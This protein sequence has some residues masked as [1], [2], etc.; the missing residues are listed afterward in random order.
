MDAKKDKYLV[1]PVEEREMENRTSD[2]EST[3]RD[4]EI[5]MKFDK[6]FWLKVQDRV[7]SKKLSW[8]R[9][10]DEVHAVCL[11]EKYGKNVLPVIIHKWP[12]RRKY[13][14]KPEVLPSLEYLISRLTEIILERDTKE[15]YKYFRVALKDDPTRPTLL[16]LAAEQNFLHVSKALVEHYP[17]LMYMYS[18]KQKEKPSYL[19]V[20][21]ALKE[22][23]DDT[24]AYLISQMRHDRV[25]KLFLC[26]ENEAQTPM[27]FY[28][29]DY[30]SCQDAKTKEPL[31][32]KTVLA[33]LDKHINPRWPYLP[34]MKEDE[35]NDSELERAF[36]SV[37]DDP[38]NYDFFFHILE[39]D[40]KGRQP[41]I[42]VATEVDEHGASLNTGM[43]ANPKF[44]AKSLS[45]LRRIA[46]S[47][48]KEAIQHPVV[49]ML[50][51][52]KWNE[53]AHDWFCVQA[54]LYVLFLTVLSFA[55]IH[56]STQDDPTQYSGK[57]NK[58]RVICE[59]LSIIFLMFYFFEEVNQAGRE[60][61]TYFK[62]PYNYF[63]WLGLILTFLV[64]PL[65][66][67]GVDS[68]WSVAALGYLFNFLRLFKFSCVTRTT[69]LY[70]KTLAKIVYRDIS[71][72]CVVFVVIF[73]GFCGSMY[74]ALKATASQKHFSNFSW[75]MLAAV[76]ALFEQQPVEE[77]Y[78][79]FRWLA[80][81]ILLSYMAM[82]IVIM[83]NILIA[84]MSYTYSEA[85]RTAK[86]QFAVDTML[87][88]ARLE[89]SRFA[90]WNLR[91]K[92]YIKGVWISE[93][94]LA[95]EMLEY[96]EDSHPWETME[97]KLTN[98][99]RLMRK[100]VR[101]VKN[102]DPLE[103]IDDKLNNL[104]K[105]VEKIPVP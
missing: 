101:R 12:Q 38:M 55:L 54:A 44:N 40:D 61:Q 96:S 93:K 92:N 59:V 26:Q 84:Q 49:R 3:D 21:L 11:M 99:R 53:F 100:V 79:K 46:E 29:G 77:D 43:I 70:T 15:D 75:L 62:D 74:M 68:Q 10:M 24:A 6:D 5:E 1:I 8:S 97:E 58:L 86:L 104:T 85:K 4:D 69:G 45:C 91:V 13:A 14:K 16:H 19:P 30:I 31:M 63:D 57:A 25:Q 39:A 32:K 42:E 102:T 72:F 48:H 41:K 94:D 36:S 28:F 2:S 80:I 76:R 35:E 83:L 64:I 81:L 67:V 71:R 73:L 89:Y 60:W 87:I 27:K 33:I 51:S 17:G 66:F 18:E 56:G 23:K 37:P 82:V 65:R 98:I 52:R 90:R 78:S 88:T 50:V 34:E 95:K 9:A 105:I 20:E 103:S 47:G 22:Y 7:K